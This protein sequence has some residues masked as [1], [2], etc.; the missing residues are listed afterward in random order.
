M[1]DRPT[2][3]QLRDRV[4]AQAV[5]LLSLAPDDREEHYTALRRANYAAALAD[6]M[7]GGEARDMTEQMESWVRQAV[8][9]IEAGGK[10]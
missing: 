3:D 8:R 7:T 5:E 6:G 2:A 4:S 1:N 9:I 10:A